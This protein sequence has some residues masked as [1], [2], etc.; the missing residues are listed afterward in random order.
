MLVTIFRNVPDPRKI[1]RST[2]ELGDLL[3]IA[4]LTFFCG[5]EDYVD[6]ELFANHRARGFVRLPYTE[7][8]LSRDT[9]ERLFRMIDTKYFEQFVVEHGKKVMD[10][11][12]SGQRPL[13][14]EKLPLASGRDIQKDK[15]VY[16]IIYTMISTF[17]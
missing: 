13:A 17:T 12:S 2:Y 4:P 11:R 8:D 14:C 5:R 7:R 3:A 1:D 16:A 6:M 9:I 10:I 15:C